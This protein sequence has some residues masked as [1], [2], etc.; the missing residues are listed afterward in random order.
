MNWPS[1]YACATD[2]VASAGAHA[3]RPI[4]WEDRHDIRTWRN[5]QLEVLRQVS[6]LTESDQDA[7]FSDVVRPQMG[8][9]APTQ[10]LFGLTLD[11]HLIGYGGIVHLNWPDRRGEVSFL[12]AT[13][14]LHDA[15]F[16]ADWRA[17]LGL[18]VPLARDTLGLHKLTTEAYEFRTRL[19]P[20]LEEAG[21]T[22]EGRLRQHHHLE[23]R[24]VTSLAHGLI[25]SD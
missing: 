2:L 13:E 6:P 21:F 18:L 9:A 16:A 5:D 20:L 23:G 10:I 7:Y 25:L 19:F 17:Y 3:L 4:R 12:S 1:G 11:E 8:Q 22:L 24:W 14:R 15:T